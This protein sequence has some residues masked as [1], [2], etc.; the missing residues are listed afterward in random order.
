M[1]TLLGGCAPLLL[2]SQ[3]QAGAGEQHLELLRHVH[4]AH[5]HT[6]HQRHLQQPAPP[7]FTT[8]NTQELMQS[9][10]HGSVKEKRMPQR[11]AGQSAIIYSRTTITLPLHSLA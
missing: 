3:A 2:C 9:R 10:R 7:P 6:V 4:P 11:K 8:S 5:H 1:A